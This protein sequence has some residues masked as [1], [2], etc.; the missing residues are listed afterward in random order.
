MKTRNLLMTAAVLTAVLA[1]G[2]ESNAAGRGGY[3]VST[4]TTQVRPVGS[5]RRD[6][7]FLT[8]GTTASGATTRPTNSRGVMDGTGINAVVP[9][10]TTAQ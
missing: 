6:G 9:T 8:T 7:T 5:Q 4:S 10:T 3:G 2:G 1:F